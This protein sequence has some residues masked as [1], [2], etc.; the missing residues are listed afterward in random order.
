MPSSVVRVVLSFPTRRSS[1]LL[2]VAACG[3]IGLMVTGWHATGLPKGSLGYIY[4]PAFIGIVIGGAGTASL[5]TYLA[6]K[7]PVN[8]LKKLLD[9]K[10]TR[11]NSSHRCISYAVF[12]RSCCTFFPYTTLFRSF[13]RCCLWQYWV[14]GDGLACYR[15]AKRLIG[16]YLLAGFH[17][18]RDW[19]CWD[20]FTGYLFSA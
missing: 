12:R 14:D 10:S 5:G 17:W 6:H 2:P 19:R 4:W 8:L 13:A 9:R 15:L 1:D 20:S 7:L 18:H 3:S 16:L 11:L